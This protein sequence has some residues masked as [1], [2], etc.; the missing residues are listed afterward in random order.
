M[1]Y[2][3]NGTHESSLIEL[4]VFFAIS[5]PIF[6]CTSTFEEQR[7]LEGG[8][9]KGGVFYFKERDGAANKPELPRKLISDEQAMEI[10]NSGYAYYKA[11]FNTE[12]YILNCIKYVD[13]DAYNKKRGHGPT[14]EPLGVE[15]INHHE[16]EYKDG[17]LIRFIRYSPDPTTGRQ[18]KVEKYDKNGKLVSRQIWIRD[19]KTAGG[20]TDWYKKSG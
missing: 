18:K 1:R 13:Q 12:G 8:G 16:Y 2:K 10:K 7:F 5:F 6:A 3:S 15:V 11:T 4:V 19:K 20:F 17:Y 9:P 14:Q